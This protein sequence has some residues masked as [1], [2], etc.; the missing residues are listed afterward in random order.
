MR[1]F[2][3]TIDCALTLAVLIAGRSSAER[4]QAAV[5]WVRRRTPPQAQ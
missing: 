2:M 3:Q 5:A 1:V 4:R